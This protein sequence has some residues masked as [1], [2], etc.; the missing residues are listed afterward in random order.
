MRQL[1]FVGSFYHPCSVVGSKKPTHEI[2]DRASEVLGLPWT[3]HARALNKCSTTHTD[4]R[5]ADCSV[6]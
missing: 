5:K 4:A 6:S 1:V 3:A 2:D